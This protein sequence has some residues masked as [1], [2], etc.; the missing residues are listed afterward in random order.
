VIFAP[1]PDSIPFFLSLNI[2][3]SMT[4]LPVSR[5]MGNDTIFVVGKSADISENLA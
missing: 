4:V 2:T 3:C 5:V 1:I